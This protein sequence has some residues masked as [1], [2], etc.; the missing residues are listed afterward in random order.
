MTVIFTGRRSNHD[1]GD[2]TFLCEQ[3]KGLYS[4]EGSFLK[5]IEWKGG[6]RL[7]SRRVLARE[8][9]RRPVVNRQLVGVRRKNGA[10]FDWLAGGVGESRSP[11]AV[12]R[13]AALPGRA[14]SW[15][16]GEV[17]GRRATVA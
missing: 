7:R 10:G 5:T 6:H 4:P 3:Y 9:H 13:E 14:Y 17:A 2:E 1:C 11:W 16:A 12:G 8:Y 15:R